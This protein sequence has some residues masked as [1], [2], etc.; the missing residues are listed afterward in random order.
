MPTGYTAD[1]QSGKITEFADF[2]MICA[3]AFGATVLMRDDPLGKPIPQRFEA[4]DY[5]EKAIDK[6]RVGLI[7]LRS[8]TP[9]QAAAE[10]DAAE[11]ERMKWR[12]E[13]EAK[14]LTQ[15][16]RYRA[17]LAEVEKWNPPTPDHIGL[18]KFMAAQLKESLDFDC[19]PSDAYAKPLPV[20]EDWLRQEMDK[21]EW[22][23]AYHEKEHRKEV[24]RTESRNKWLDDL[25]GSLTAQ[26]K[27]KP[28]AT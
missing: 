19:S 22:D 8:L 5:H 11:D 4:S 6:T 10:R 9:A 12:S 26:M 7:R 24:E 18:K 16:A 25:R 17:M 14:K 3:R 13:Y 27:E 1:V 23:L 28:D 20:P 21:A 15:A 2:A